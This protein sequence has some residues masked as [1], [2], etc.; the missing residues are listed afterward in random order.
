MAL[1][2]PYVT[3]AELKAYVGIGDAIADTQLTDALDSVSEE[4][5][6]HCGRQFN[7]AG[8]ATSRLFHREDTTLVYVDDFHT[9]TGLVIETDDDGDGVFETTWSAGD[10]Q[11]EPL[12][13]TMEGKTGWPYWKIRAV[14]DYTFPTA[15]GRRAVVRVTA[16]WGWATVPPPVKAACRILAAETVKL[17]EAPFGVAGYGEFG[18]VRVRSNPMAAKKLNPYVRTPIMAWGE[19]S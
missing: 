18:P 3:V 15:A 1:G 7:D 16:R 13:G 8:S 19:V 9:T 2:D 6:S 11:L 10:Y 14:G 17:R 5:E 12:N 4:I